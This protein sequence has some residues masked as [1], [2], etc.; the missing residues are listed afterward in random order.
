MVSMV[1]LGVTP[2]GNSVVVSAAG[3]SVVVSAERFSA[4]T[5]GFDLSAPDLEFATV[6]ETPALTAA[7]PVFALSAPDLEFAAE[8]ETPALTAAVPVFALSAPDLEFATEFE[9]PALSIAANQ[10]PLEALD[11]EFARELEAP[12][13]TTNDVTAPVVNS[14]SISDLT[15]TANIEE[16]SGAATCI[17]AIAD[18]AEDPTYTIAGGWVGAIYESGSFPVVVGDARDRVTLAA[19]PDGTRELTV[20]YRDASGNLSGPPE[21]LTVEI[22]TTPA[23]TWTFTGSVVDTIP[24]SSTWAFTGSVIDTVGAN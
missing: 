19:T 13:L 20:Y 1:R 16:D 18:P 6:L 2:A 4:K 15:I 24:A 8:F 22:D 9:T 7:V 17:W 11:L 14:I 12:A 3:N 21:R 23:S 5:T 10:F